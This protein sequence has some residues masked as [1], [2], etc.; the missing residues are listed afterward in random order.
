MQQMLADEIF[1][2]E[3]ILWRHGVVIMADIEIGLGGKEG[4]RLR[5][6][7]AVKRTARRIT[8]EAEHMR[9]RLSRLRGEARA[10]IEARG[11]DA[12]TKATLRR[13]WSD[14]EYRVKRAEDA[15]ETAVNYRLNGSLCDVWDWDEMIQLVADKLIHIDGT[16]SLGDNTATPESVNQWLKGSFTFEERCRVGVRNGIDRRLRVSR[17]LSGA[18]TYTY[19]YAYVASSPIVSASSPVS[20]LCM[21][22]ELYEV[23]HEVWG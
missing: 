3:E 22:C 2:F 5:N 12:W 19:A 8:Q 16:C 6:I 7:V 15:L 23:R 1:K 4:D 9:E 17:I 10:R 13:C 14:C 18:Y 21:L 20:S 11:Y